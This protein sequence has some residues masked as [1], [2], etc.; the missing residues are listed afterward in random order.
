MPVGIKPKGTK[1]NSNIVKHDLQDIPYE[2]RGNRGLIEGNNQTAD[3]DFILLG[4]QASQH[5]I[6][7][8]FCLFLVVYCGTICGN[9]LI[10]TLV[11][12][13][14]NLQS[15]MYFFLTHLSVSDIWLATVIVP[16]MLYSLLNNGSTLTF[17]RCM[18]QFFFFCIPEIFECFLL[19]VMSYDRYMAICNPLHYTS[20]VTSTCCVILAGTCWALGFSCAMIFSITIS[21]LTFCGPNIIDYLFCDLVPL[22]EIACSD[23]HGIELEVIVLCTI[24]LFIPITIIIISYINIIVTILQFQSNISRQKAFSTCSA[25]LTVVIMFYSTLLTV[26]LFPKGGPSLNL[27]KILSLLYTVFTPLINPM[28]YSLRNKEIKKSLQEMIDKCKTIL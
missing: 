11:S 25:H 5:S 12:T 19:T 7:F 3:N 9:L 23:T 22:V 21:T 24:V 14:K 10:I 15:P 17:I 16:N 8:L 26:Y 18:T 28:I 2:Y 4:F 6:V 20:I 13:S 27:S 1:F